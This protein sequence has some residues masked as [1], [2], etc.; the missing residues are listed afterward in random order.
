[1]KALIITTRRTGSTFLI[2]CLNTHPQ[3]RAEHEIL[4][5]GFKPVA[6]SGFFERYSRIGKLWRYFVAGAWRPVH[7][8]NA[9]YALPDAPVKIFKAMYHQLQDPRARRYLVHDKSIRVIHLRRDNLLKRYVSEVLAHKRKGKQAWHAY[10]QLPVVTTYISPQA[11]I[12]NMRRTQDQILV[13][14]R[15]FSDHPKIELVYERMIEDQTLSMEINQTISDFLSVEPLPV[16]SHLVKTNVDDLRVLIENY[17][18]VA[19]ALV[20][21]DFER[22]LGNAG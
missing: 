21:T 4:F 19:Q 13:Y 11:A 6:F 7:L 14:G 10:K 12:D 5:Q 17:N 2:D 20:G 18:E 22:F 15:L 1:M 3:I 9:F 8:L 16:Q